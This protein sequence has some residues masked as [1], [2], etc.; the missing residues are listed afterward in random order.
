MA[1]TPPAGSVI[2]FDFTTPLFPLV[3]NFTVSSYT[4]PL[5]SAISLDF[6]VPQIPLDFTFGIAPP[7]YIPDLR[8]PCLSAR[9]TGQVYKQWVFYIYQGQQRVRRYLVPSDPKTPPQL[10]LRA[11]FAAGVKAWQNLSQSDKLY[12][13]RV[14]VRKKEP[15]TSLNAF[16]SAWMRDKI[17]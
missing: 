17:T 3:Y 14:G 1:Y 15:I 11:K 13:R 9:A 16:L 8:Y 12:W 5:G 6:T 2:L 4:P 10:S 7:P